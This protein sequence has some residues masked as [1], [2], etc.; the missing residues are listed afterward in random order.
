MRD[1]PEVQH[2]RAAQTK[3]AG[4]ELALDRQGKQGAAEL[5]VAFFEAGVKRLRDP[6]RR[7]DF[8]LWA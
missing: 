4:R 7:P 8:W 5:R 3:R 2:A 1:D 6:G